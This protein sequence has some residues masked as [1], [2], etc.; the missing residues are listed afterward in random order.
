M[1]INTAFTKFDDDITLSQSKRSSI[2]TSRNA[3]REKIK[4]FFKA[5]KVKAPS[6]YI[7]GS[8]ATHTALA[9]L[10]GEEVDIDDGLY[11]NNCDSDDMKKWPTPKNI[12]KDIIEALDGHTQD[13]CEDKTSCVRVIYQ[14]NYHV[15]IPVYIMKDDHA[16]LA[17]AKSNTWVLSDSKDFK[18]WYA[19]KIK[20]DPE[21][22]RRITRYIKAWRDYKKV[23]MA[24]IEIA[25]LVAEHFVK[26]DS[27]LQSLKNTLNAMYLDVMGNQSIYK[28]VSPYENLWD[29][30][31]L[32]EKT[33]IT[34]EL[35]DFLND[36]ANVC[37]VED[38]EAS[39]ILRENFGDRFP[40][41]E[42]KR[43]SVTSTYNE[44]PKPWANI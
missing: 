7:Q 23:K 15:D 25:I 28:P 27:D 29:G 5:K 38:A 6:F 20:T 2:I 31:S 35:R 3:I 33:T 9:P 34:D 30:K 10:S 14:S 24:S 19:D 11:L 44:G 36:V 13:G 4:S 42:E 1:N 26:D 37:K 43:D 16:Y 39:S 21:Q 22:A 18:D 8:F 12:H 40:Q 32:K 17:N 41:I